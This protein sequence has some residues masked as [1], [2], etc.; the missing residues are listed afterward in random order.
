MFI[1]KRLIVPFWLLFF[2]L[3][4]GTAFAAP[5][6]YLQNASGYP[7]QTVSVPVFLTNDAAGAVCVQA[8]K[9]AVA[10]IDP[11]TPPTDT[12]VI[13]SLGDCLNGVPAADS[14]IVYDPA[15]LTYSGTIVGTATTAARASYRDPNDQTTVIYLNNGKGPVANTINTA[16]GVVTIGVFGAD[17]NDPL[18]DDILVYVRFTI[19]PAAQVGTTIPL[20]NTPSAANRA[21][22]KIVVDPASTGAE[23]KITPHITYMLTVNSIGNGSVTVDTGSLSWTDS[24]GTA[25]YNSGTRVTLTATAGPGSTF[26]GWS[27]ACTGTGLCTVTVDQ[28]RS[29][30]STFSP[31]L[32][33]LTVQTTGT[34]SGS[35][36]SIPSGIACITGSSKGCSAPFIYGEKVTLAQ[37]PIYSTFTGWTGDCSGATGCEVYMNAA[38]S[39]TAS[40]TANPATVKISNS[41]TRY[42]EIGPT[43]DLITVTGKSVSTRDIVFTENVVMTSPVSI[44]LKGGYTDNAFS[45]RTATSA[46]VID[47]S[48]KIRNGTLR[49]ERLK[50]R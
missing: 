50:V 45:S 19:N 13:G 38:R 5:K 39:V 14:T 3:G 47:G 2:T 22:Q 6:I 1:C 35:L 41:A 25:S 16:N 48:L 32:L 27:G 11:Y 30:T 10:A 4:V 33:D 31:S 12:A 28:A 8:W 34:G 26:T 42:Y 18:G 36:N 43:L 9:D 7:G 21:A 40:F 15:L 17:S 46:T 49:V 24:T 37:I 44:L 20:T 23:I 29:V